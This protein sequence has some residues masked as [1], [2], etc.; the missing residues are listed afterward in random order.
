MSLE[1]VDDS[2]ESVARVSRDASA[3]PGLVDFA[4]PA[5]EA[6]PP[7]VPRLEVDRNPSPLLSPKARYLA[8]EADS[9]AATPDAPANLRTVIHYRRPSEFP[10]IPPPKKGPPL[11]ESLEG[12]AAANASTA[13][14]MDSDDLLDA[15][16][17]ADKACQSTGQVA[18]RRSSSLPVASDDLE[19]EGVS[20]VDEDEVELLGS[21]TQND[22]ENVAPPSSYASSDQ[23]VPHRRRTRGAPRL[24]PSSAQYSQ[25]TTSIRPLLSSS[26]SSTRATSAKPTARTSKA[27]KR[28]KKRARVERISW[29]T[30]DLVDSLPPRR[31]QRLEDIFGRDSSDDST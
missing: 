26:S 14:D 16:L 21:D 24:R 1:Y 29:N 13:F 5:D 30:Q 9:P 3:A 12:Y 6:G 11:L 4:I 28:V 17:V 2:F 15:F 19:G 10:I 27:K 7:D 31:A 20:L 8:I 22:I 25:A 23:P 18:R